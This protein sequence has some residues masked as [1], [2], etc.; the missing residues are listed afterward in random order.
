MKRILLIALLLT[1]P[2][3]AD[4]S[5]LVKAAKKK[6]GRGVITNETVRKNATPSSGSKG[7]APGA[8]PAPP[9]STAVIEAEQKLARDDADAHVKVEEAAVAQLERDVAT[10][11]LSYYA[12]NDPDFRDRVITARFLD[13]QAKLAATRKELAQAREASAK[14]QLKS[15]IV[16]DTKKDE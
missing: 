7:G 5:D 13:M 10:M 6:P 12:E 1:V 14:L 11:E 15:V 2:L 9:K 3:L 16:V 8:V 4:D